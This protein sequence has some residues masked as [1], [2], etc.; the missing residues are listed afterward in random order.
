MIA[1]E[2]SL[3]NIP[4][5]SLMATTRENAAPTPHRRPRLN[6]TNDKP[7]L[8]I[9][10][11]SQSRLSPSQR[12]H[13]RTRGGALP[14]HPRAVLQRTWVLPLALTLVV[15]AVYVADPNESNVA[16]KFLFL[17]YKLDDQHEH[18]QY[19]KGPRDIAFVSFYT[20]FLTF[21]RE[22]I[23]AMVLRP[24]ARYCGIRSRAKQA[25]FMEQMYTV[26]YFA[27]AGLLGLYT[28]KQSP[29]LWYFR[30]RGMYEGYPHVVHT[31]VFKFYYLFQAAYW[32][33][34]AIVMALGQEKPRKDF[35]ELMAHHILT[36][37]LIF[38]S[39][40][41]HFTYIG[42]FVYIT[43]D[44]SDLF[45]AIS[46]TLNYLDH[47]AQYATFALCIALWVYLRHYLNLAI[48]YSVATEYS[49]V[50][51]FELDWAAQ[52]YKC[53]VAQLG[54]LALLAA[55]QGL[56]LFWLRCLLRTAYRYVVSGVAKD[57]R[58]EAEEEEGEAGAE[59]K[60]GEG[61]GGLE[62]NKSQDLR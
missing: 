34:Q 6:S 38:L 12:L 35:K 13:H 51:P 42:I 17:S 39:Y 47:P 50:G 48:L 16:H 56:N 18:V 57:D 20:V 43:H 28:M 33:Q 44:I 26:C 37:T 5:T 53:R 4:S 27:F 29:G 7:L 9:R 19:G 45:L 24:L 2:T 31:A 54:T 55:L 3:F 46:K 62:G 14:R 8:Q 15:I 21:I 41:F 60:V 49:A 11:H 40:R 22:F 58:S 23:M 1:A 10:S 61:M 30:T 36:L 59:S 32:A 52:Q 25:R